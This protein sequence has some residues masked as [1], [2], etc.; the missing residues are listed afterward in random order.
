MFGDSIIGTYANVIHIFCQ[1]NAESMRYSRKDEDKNIVGI[2]K[3][4]RI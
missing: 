3:V 1:K 2:R 4:I